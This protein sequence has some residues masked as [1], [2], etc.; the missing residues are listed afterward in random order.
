MEILGPSQKK[1]AGII[2]WKKIGSL[3]ILGG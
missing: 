3:I 2:F 1:C